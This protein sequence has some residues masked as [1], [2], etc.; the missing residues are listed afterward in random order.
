VTPGVDVLLVDDESV[1]RDAALRV[2]EA[3]GLGVASTGSGTAGL[4]HPAAE[5]CRVVVC[6]LI[7]PDV[8]GVDVVREL[9][10][11]RPELPIVV[12][13]GYA[14]REAVS[15][16]EEAGASSFLAKPFD[17]AELLAAVRGALEAGSRGKEES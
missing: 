8:S 11:R 9:R 14:S 6:D 7:L 5:S 1:I 16:A 17:D 12:I 10:R 15:R 3:A 13:T 4:A 2:L